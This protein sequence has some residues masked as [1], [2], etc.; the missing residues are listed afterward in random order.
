MIATSEVQALPEEGEIVLATHRELIDHEVEVSAI[1]E[2]SSRRSDG[3]EII[4]STLAVIEGRKGGAITAVSYF[5]ASRYRIV[6][7]AENFKVAEKSMNNAVERKRI[8]LEKHHRTFG[9]RRE[10]SKKANESG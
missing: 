5:G 4:K 6:M 7:G 8:I 2:F 9:L 10:K 3:V 1:R